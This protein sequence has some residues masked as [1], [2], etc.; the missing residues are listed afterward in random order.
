MILMNVVECLARK[1]TL[2]MHADYLLHFG[3][4][5]FNTTWLIELRWCCH[6]EFP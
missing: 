6:A 5:M 1:I 3:L 2:V 4:Q